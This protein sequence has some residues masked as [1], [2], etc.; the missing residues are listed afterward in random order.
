MEKT[1][2]DI[3]FDFRNDTKK[4][5]PDKD[6]QKLYEYHK[7]LWTKELPNGKRIDL[8][9]IHNNNGQLLLKNNVYDNFSSDRMFPHFVDKYNNRFNGWLNEIEVN[10]LKYKVRTIGGHI[11]FPAHQKNGSTINQA[12]GFGKASTIIA[13]R[14][15]LTLECIRCLYLNIENPL[16]EVLSRYE[17]Y[18]ELFINFNGYVNYFLLQ[19]LLDENGNIIFVLPLDNFSRSPL[20]KTIEEYKLYQKNVIS[21][22]D[23]RNER[24]SKL[25]I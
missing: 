12:R 17:D 6:S 7:F 14:F 10:E 24:I 18:F 21:I 15:D 1:V 9:I 4:G 23:K 22:I 16:S 2:I 5:D 25:N 13:D 19:D 3:N 20:P 8:I 11:I